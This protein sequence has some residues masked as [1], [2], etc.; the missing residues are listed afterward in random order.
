MT[1]QYVVTVDDL[2]KVLNNLGLTSYE[3]LARSMGMIAITAQIGDLQNQLAVVV[4]QRTADN[5]K[6]DS[7]IST[8]RQEQD[9]VFETFRT[10]QEAERARLNEETQGK[11]HEIESLIALLRAQLPDSGG[12]GTMFSA[13]RASGELRAVKR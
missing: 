5:M 1:Q 12:G 3:D 7:A 9:L 6:V 2:V 10:E 8:F 4:A 11:I 13:A